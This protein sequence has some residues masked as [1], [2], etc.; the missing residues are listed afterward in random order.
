MGQIQVFLDSDV[1]I[2][3]LLSKTGAS[4]E[5]IYNTKT[6]KITTNSVQEE[7][8]EVANK[9]KIT[10]KKQTEKM[11][12]KLDLIKINL[13]KSQL[14]SKYAKFVY[15]NKDSHVIAGAHKSKSRFL[16]TYNTRHYNMDLIKNDLGIIVLKPGNFLQYLRSN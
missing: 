5:L 9:L 1:L 10:N 15:D 6:V 4:F 8:T 12:N 14:T 2:S 3:S 7:V 11:L 16:L 13:S